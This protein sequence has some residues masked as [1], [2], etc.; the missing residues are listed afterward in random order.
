LDATFWLFELLMDDARLETEDRARAGVKRDGDRDAID[1][2]PRKAEDEI[3][4]V[5]GC[6]WWIE[7]DG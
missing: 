5:D 4:M 6:K 3:I 2:I 7:D 1:A